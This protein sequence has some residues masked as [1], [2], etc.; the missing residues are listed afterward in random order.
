M[1]VVD[2]FSGCGG[3]SLGFQNAGFEIAAAYDNWDKAIQVY[4]CN[5]DHPIY[6]TD[7][8]GLTDFTEIRQQNPDIIIGGPPCQDFSSAGKRN[9]DGGR[10][11]LTIKYAEIV[12]DIKPKYFVMENVDRVE[13]SNAFQ[14]AL[15]IIKE[16]GYGVTITVLDASLCGVP[17]KRKRFFM[18]GE[19]GGK[20]NAIEPYLKERLTSKPMTVR[21]YLG[22]SL[23]MDHY[24][25]HPRNYNRR[26]V[27]SIDEPAPTIRGVNRPVP[28]GYTGHPADTTSVYEVRPLTTIERSYLQTFPN[29][30][31][32]DIDMPKTHLEQMIGNAVP[33][34]LAEYVAIS[35]RNYIEKKPSPALDSIAE[36]TELF[37]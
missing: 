4:Q 18:I 36:Q 25:R 23:G 29:G 13:K 35:L 14:I 37:V 3:M 6:N 27:F 2:L 8:G 26:G 33:V 1:R 11:D 22:E 5:F 7:L 16:A 12:S 20:D 30:Y 32:S 24:Y 28:A 9:E 15:S 34:N 31:F 19:L 21:D 10:A 17:Q